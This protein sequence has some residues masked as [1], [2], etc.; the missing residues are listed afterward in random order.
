MHLLLFFRL[1]Q[2]NAKLE[3]LNVNVAGLRKDCRVKKN[4]KICSKSSSII[5]GSLENAVYQPSAQ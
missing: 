3:L 2:P 5:T 4:E 1:A